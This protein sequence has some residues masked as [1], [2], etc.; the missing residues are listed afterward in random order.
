MTPQQHLVD[1]PCPQC[2]LNLLRSPEAITP[3]IVFCDFCL[4]GGPY[5]MVMEGRSSVNA[6]YITR[7][8]AKQI[9]REILELNF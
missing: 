8:R 3:A 1:V 7:D 2:K 9:L 4:A 5:D 6:N